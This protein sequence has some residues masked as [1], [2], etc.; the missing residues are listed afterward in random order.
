VKEERRFQSTVAHYLKGRPHYA[1]RLIQLVARRT[2]LTSAHNVLDL[3]CGPGQLARAFAPLARSVTAMDPEPLTLA[4]AQSL[5]EAC[6]SINFVAGGSQDLS[7]GLG[8]FHLVVMGRSFHWMDR[9][10]TL[11]R[12]DGLIAPGG[13]VVLFDTSHAADPANA[14]R[15]RYNAIRRSY[16]GHDTARSRRHGEGWVAHESVLLDSAFSEVD[17]CYVIERREMD[18]TLLMDRALS[19]SS[20]SPERVGDHVGDMRREIE[21][22]LAEIAPDGVLTEAVTSNALIGQRPG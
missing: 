7:P 18:A 8:R 9:M 5:S 13:A 21:A 2:G 15:D 1:D 20:S 12:L 11:R 10:E 4:A 6:P 17:G 16:A 14:W 3:G 22:L 19:M